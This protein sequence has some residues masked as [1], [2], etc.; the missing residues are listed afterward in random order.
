M[1]PNELKEMIGIEEKDYGEIKARAF[2]DLVSSSLSKY[3]EIKRQVFVESRGDGHAGR[4]DIVFSFKG[5]IYP[6]EIDR[7]SVR[8]KSRFKVLSLGTED[9]FC[10]TRSP[11]CVIRA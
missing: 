5:K 11:Y 7:K 2:E 6:I 8:T 10:I 3:G 1:K 9:A 4:I